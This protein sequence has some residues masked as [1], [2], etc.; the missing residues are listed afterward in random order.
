MFRVRVTCFKMGASRDTYLKHTVEA[1]R[2]PGP[3]QSETEGKL[4]CINNF[5][6]ALSHKEIGARQWL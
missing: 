2:H 6:V 5:F 3:G 1:G 4:D